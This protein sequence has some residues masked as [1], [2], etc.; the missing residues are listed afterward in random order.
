MG[1]GNGVLVSSDV[2]DGRAGGQIPPLAAQVWVPMKKWAPLIRL[3][4]LP[5]Q[6]YKFQTF[7]LCKFVVLLPQ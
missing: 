5:K 2:T 7:S 1:H 6:F 4:L 3:A